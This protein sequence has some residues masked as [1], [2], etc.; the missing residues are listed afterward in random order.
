MVKP[1]NDNQHINKPELFICIVAKIGTDTR[2]FY[3]ILSDE[4]GL[5]GYDNHTLKVTDIATSI[6]DVDIPKSPCDVRYNKLIDYCNS[7]RER[8]SKRDFLVYAVIDAI[9]QF[10]EPKLTGTDK[11]TLSEVCYII[12]QFKLP[13]EIERLREVYGRQCIVISLYDNQLNRLKFLSSKIAAEHN[14][15][16][17]PEAWRSTAI[18]LINRDEE[19]EEIEFGQNVRNAFHAADVVIDVSI[20]PKNI[21]QQVER[22]L[23]YFFGSPDASPSKCEFGMHAAH[24]AALQSAD[25]SRQVGAAVLDDRGTV[26]VTGCNEAPSPRGGAYW[27][28]DQHDGRDIVLGLDANEEQ[29]SKILRN[30]L[31]CLYND[32][33]IDKD[34]LPASITE[35]YRFL[36]VEEAGRRS[37]TA[38]SSLFDILEF[39]RSVH[40]EMMVITSAARLG[41][42]LEG[43]TLFCTT[44]PCHNCSKHIVSSGIKRV[45]YLEPYPK[46]LVST[47]HK[48]SIHVLDLLDGGIVRVGLNE[49]YLISLW[50]W[51]HTDS[52]LCTTIKTSVRIKTER[53]RN[54]L[55][56]KLIQKE[57]F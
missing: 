44:F 24:A 57:M 50:G 8:T 37:A 36:R 42:S 13:E 40:A 54:G 16:P 33:W 2:D 45:I 52:R 29:K 49:L 51:A 38:S 46:S 39:G 47:L 32:G 43:K 4:L 14:E 31:E 28:D 34:D 53:R 20:S 26:L 48:D 1:V 18:D 12:D 19:E 22:F 17:D 7:L 23:R 9:A 3:R 30:F 35:M 55:N 5:Y 21:E 11:K 6:E 27:E 15:N 56:L 41:I 10:R 25:L